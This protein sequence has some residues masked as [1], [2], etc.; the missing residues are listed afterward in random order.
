MRRRIT[1]EPKANLLHGRGTVRSRAAM[2]SYGLV[3]GA[4]IPAPSLAALLIRV[5]TSLQGQILAEPWRYL[6][7]C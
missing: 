7:V 1:S 5:L 4:A 2:Q 6:Y 3:W